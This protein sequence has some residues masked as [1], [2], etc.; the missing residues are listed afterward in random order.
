MSA[1]FY[2]VKAFGMVD[3]EYCANVKAVCPGVS[4]GCALCGIFS[5]GTCS[6]VCIVGG[7]F[8]GTKA[9]QCKGV[10]TEA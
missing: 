6:E 9:I 7:L 3:E 10:M 5:P 8:C 1:C 4:I 2:F